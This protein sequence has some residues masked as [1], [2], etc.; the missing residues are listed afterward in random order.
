MPGPWGFNF[1]A[2]LLAAT[3]GPTESAVLGDLYPTAFSNGLTGGWI[4]EPEERDRNSGYDR[5]LV[6]VNQRTNDGVQKVFQVD[7][8]SPGDYAITLALGDADNLQVYQYAQLLDGVTPVLTIADADGTTAGFFDD[9]TGV[10]YDNATWPGSNTPVTI[11]MAGS[12]L[13]VVIGSPDVQLGST[14]LAHLS[15]AAVGG[16]GGTSSPKRPLTAF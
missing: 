13:F 1:R 12:T 15:I 7:L 3:D 14:T 5:R 6:G 2:T 8:P 16:G 11:T 4:D 9:A 10:D